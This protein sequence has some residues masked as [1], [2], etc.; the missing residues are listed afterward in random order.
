MVQNPDALHCVKSIQIRSFFW[1][2]AGKYESEKTPYLDTYHA[3]LLLDTWPKLNLGS[4]KAVL[5]VSWTFYVQ[6]F[7]EVLICDLSYVSALF[8]P[9]T[10]YCSISIPLSTF[11]YNHC[12]ALHDLV[13]IVYFW[14]LYFTE[15]NTSPWLFLMFFKL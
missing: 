4:W 1:L 3:V 8:Q 7:F 6:I 5:N 11:V 10:G 2:N 9:I 15:T 14:K 13:L 12:D